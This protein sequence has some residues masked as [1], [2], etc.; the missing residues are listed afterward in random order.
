MS[1]DKN[2]FMDL[3]GRFVNGSLDE[4]QGKIFLG[5]LQKNPDWASTVRENILVDFLLQKL[6]LNEDH[7]AGF[8]SSHEDHEDPAESENWSKVL[9]DLVH[10]E[11][12]AVSLNPPLPEPDLFPK[13]ESVWLKWL[14]PKNKMP[15]K[16]KYSP[17]ANFF[18]MLQ[19]GIL[20]ALV[21]GFS[22][23]HYREINDRYRENDPIPSARIA[24][25]VDVVW[26]DDSE[27]YERGQGIFSNKIKL[28]SGIIKLRFKNNAVL[29]LQGP[30]ELVVNSPQNAFCLHGSISATVPKEAAGFGINTPFGE[31]IDRGTMFSLNIDSKKVDLDVIKGRV[32]VASTAN[33]IEQITEGSGGTVDLMKDFTPRKANFDFFMKSEVFDQILNRFVEKKLAVKSE[34]DLRLNENPNLL[35]NLDF[36]NVRKSS[37]ENSAKNGSRFLPEALLKGTVS[38]EGRFHS[39]RSVRFRNLKDLVLLPFNRQFSGLTLVANVRLDRLKNQGNVILSGSDFLQEP[40]AF[41]WQ[42]LK[43]GRL[44]FLVNN[45]QKKENEKLGSSYFRFDSE[46]C[47]TY[48]KLNSWT[49]VVLVVDPQNKKIV[50]YLNGKMI[51]EIPWK[52]PIPLHI[53]EAAIGNFVDPENRNRAQFLDGA[54]D[55]FLLF[56]RPL[57]SEEIRRL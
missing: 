26:A 22:I 28:V 18:F 43:D 7:F 10:W 19:L 34:R 39:T 37:I 35:I 56:D 46:P 16:V 11:K 20:I 41:L 25:T 2:L 44:Q 49:Q 30:S 54:L 23:A 5:L 1:D 40:G 42:I 55:E 29:L 51:S 48:G 6:F 8:P 38:D 36:Q 15:K 9:D 50:H 13:K 21:F 57:T 4:E 24:E 47:F 33:K 31:F 27:S 12:N 14:Q 45:R 17:L 32:D 53:S 3:A 52:N